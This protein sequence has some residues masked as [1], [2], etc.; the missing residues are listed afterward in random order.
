MST[1]AVQA[2]DVHAHYGDYDCGKPGLV[3]ELMTGDGKVVAERARR[4]KIRLTIVSPLEALLPRGHGNAVSGNRN[5]AQ[6]VAETPGLLQYVV[7]D[8]RV[9]ET[10]RQA[11]EMLQQPHCV[12]IKIHP[13]E[14]VYP[15]NEFGAAI[16]EFAAKHKAVVL[17]HSSERNSLAADLVDWANRFP[18][19]KLILAHIGCGWDNDYTH[20]VRGVQQSRNGNVFADTSSARSIT[21]NLIEWAVRQIGADRV[22]FG[23]DTPLYVTAMQR[24]RIDRADLTDAEKNKILHENAEKLFALPLMS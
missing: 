11:E 16:F 21:P 20:Q 22:L 8:P 17:S 7:I 3:N 15:V 10:Y 14:H 23:T 12:G 19:M 24:V 5:A 1:E 4:A 9:P 2:I 13:E 18:E 6:I